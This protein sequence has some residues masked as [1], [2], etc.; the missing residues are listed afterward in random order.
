MG[1]GREGAKLLLPLHPAIPGV[2]HHTVTCQRTIP[3]RSAPGLSHG[4]FSGP[5]DPSGSSEMGEGGHQDPEQ[6][7]KFK[8]AWWTGKGAE[9]GAGWS[10]GCWWVFPDDMGSRGE[11]PSGQ[12]WGCKLEGAAGGG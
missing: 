10:G 8:I 6:E 3:L 1:Q 11:G 9:W 7:Q 2:S 5:E 12:G 4:M